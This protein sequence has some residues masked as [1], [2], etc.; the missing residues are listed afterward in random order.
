MTSLAWRFVEALALELAPAEREVAL[1]D[2]I[3][4][5]TN[6]WHGIREILGLVMRRQLQLWKSWRPWL[7]SLGVAFP[8]SLI[9]MG[10]S[11][12]ISRELGDRFSFGRHLAYSTIGSMDGISIVCQIVVLLIC[13][14]AVGFTVKSLSQRTFVVSAFC[15]FLS[16]LFC[17]FR[18]HHQSMSRFCLLL[19]L[20]PA[21]AGFRFSR[22]GKTL[23][24]GWVVALSVAGTFSMAV[25]AGRANFWT[26]NWALLGPTW[27][28][29]VRRSGLK[30]ILE[31]GNTSL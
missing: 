16:C 27:Y 31:N 13:S 9:L 19:F 25:L 1:G 11:F 6:A 14:W 24:R 8:C 26:L 4:T 12:A 17:L 2:L 28:L 22:R 30:S 20:P 5:R 29:S 18:F 3:E 21:I 10:F 23:G 7:A 15:C